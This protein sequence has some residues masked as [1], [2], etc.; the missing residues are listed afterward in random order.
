ME[1]TKLHDYSYMLISQNQELNS[2]VNSVLGG[3]FGLKRVT[4]S[5]KALKPVIEDKVDLVLIDQDD[6]GDAMQSWMG[7]DTVTKVVLI[8]NGEKG[9]RLSSS[10]GSDYLFISKAM[11]RQ[12]LLVTISK[13][14]IELE[15]DRYKFLSEDKE[16]KVTKE[17][18]IKGEESMYWRLI[19]D[20]VEYIESHGNYIKI[21][22]TDG[23]WKIRNCTIKNIEQILPDVDFCRI[24]RSYI[25]RIDRVNNFNSL[26]L[27]IA[28][29]ILPIGRSYR[30]DF[31]SCLI[32]L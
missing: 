27:E 16:S 6:S 31:E 3:I 19:L 12:Q 7:S 1:L 32:K 24:H 22:D 20:K 2:D 11:L 18:F 23:K 13:L 10:S 8:G 14:I 9:G 17:L 15:M 5:T 29:K 26:N 4:V 25:V 28:K 21:H 30:H